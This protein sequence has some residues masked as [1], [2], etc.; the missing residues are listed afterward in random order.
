MPAPSSAAKRET[1]TVPDIQPNALGR[2]LRGFFSNSLP[3]VR[4]LS[5]NTVLGYRDSFKLLLRFLEQRLGRPA[6]AIDFPDLSP[7]NL[8][9]FLEHLETERGN[10]VATRNARLVAAHAFA[11]YATSSHPEHFELCQQILAVPFKRGDERTVGYLETD[12]M[13]ALLQ[14]PDLQTASGRRDRTLLLAMFNTGAR[15]QEILDLRPCDI[16]FERPTQA[17]LRGKGGKQRLCPLW[18]DTVRALRSL[19]RE[20]GVPLADESPVFRNR[21]GEPLTRF[22]IRYL[23]AKHARTASLSAATLASKRVHPHL[24]RHTTATSLLQSGVDLVTISHWLG[25]ASIES[26]NR[27][28]AVNLATKRAA[29]EKAQPTACGDTGVASWRSDESVL[30]WLEAL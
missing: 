23:L 28:V 24:L 20:R 30:A 17:L 9:A 22:G 8:L 3:H 2:A 21:R 26:T 25:H 14:A 19:L 5:R 4:G 7:Q 29:I 16:Q 13:R 6:A 11:R 10:C 1:T 15:V 18:P 12:E 27:Y